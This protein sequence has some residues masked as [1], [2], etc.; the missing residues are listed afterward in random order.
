MKNFKGFLFLAVCLMMLLLAACSSEEADSSTSNESTTPEG[1]QVQTSGEQVKEEE[2]EEI[3]FGLAH[4]YPVELHTSK[5]LDL[6]AELVKEKSD[7]KI[8]MKVYPTG[9]LYN[10]ISMPDAVSTGQIEMG[11][12]T[13]EMWTSQVPAA[14]F[15]VLPLFDDYKHVHA[16]IDN[17]INDIFVEE[18]NKVGAHPLIW[19]DFGFGYYASKE[20]PL[21]TPESFKGKRI[22]TTSPLMAKYVELAGGSPVTISGSEVTQALQKGTIDGALSGVS[23]FTAVQYYEFT[24]NYSGPQNAGV[25]LI[26]VNLEWWNSLSE[27]AREIISEAADESEKWT[28]VEADIIYNESV[29]QLEEEGMTLVPVE[30]ESFKA[31]EDELATEYLSRSGEVGK[32]ILEIIESTK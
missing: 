15:V 4:N 14:E 28:T 29:A 11:A 21:S 12:N 32:E 13:L 6:F 26:T 17:G 1:D 18:L 5:G 19:S 16:A 8:N 31:I 9:Q 24:K 25:V 27:A 23:G 3:E 7:G 20:E 30:K 10:D 22:R 2:L